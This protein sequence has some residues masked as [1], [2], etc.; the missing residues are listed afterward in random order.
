MSR[1]QSPHDCYF[2]K[3]KN[4]TK[5]DTVNCTVESMGHTLTR[6][7]RLQPLVS[8]WIS[9]ML[10]KQYCEEHATESVQLSAVSEHKTQNEY[11]PKSVQLPSNTTWNGILKIHQGLKRQRLE[12]FQSMGCLK[13][14]ICSSVSLPSCQEIHSQEYRSEVRTHDC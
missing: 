10:Q 3:G 14:S 9:C 6:L 7:S 12:V 4:N 2:Q 11:P 5:Q 8:R 1:I 13:K